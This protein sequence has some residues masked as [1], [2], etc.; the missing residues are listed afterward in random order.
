M[1]AHQFEFEA[2]KK[3]SDVAVFGN[4][5]DDSWR[6]THG[7]AIAV[8]VERGRQVSVGQRDCVEF[9]VVGPAGL[10]HP[11]HT[12]ARDVLEGL[13]RCVV[14][15]FGVAFGELGGGQA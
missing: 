9:G 2:S 14:G 3:G 10:L 13:L 12:S 1:G 8:A 4:R 7:E 15:A 5:D 6:A 11:C